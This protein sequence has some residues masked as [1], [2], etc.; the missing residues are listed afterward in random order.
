MHRLP[1]FSA[2]FAPRHLTALS[3]LVCLF[4][5]PFALRASDAQEFA[6]YLEST[7][8]YYGVF[9][10][11]NNAPLQLLGSKATLQ[12]DALRTF[13][14]GIPQRGILVSYGPY[15]FT[16]GA[17]VQ[18]G[19]YSFTLINR[20]LFDIREKL[21]Q[22]AA[23]EEG[24]K[25][26][27]QAKGLVEWNGAWVSSNALRV[28]LARENAILLPAEKRLATIPAPSRCTTCSGLGLIQQGME[29]IEGILM[30]KYTN[31]P[32]CKGTG[33]EIPMTNNTPNSA[34]NPDGSSNAPPV[35]FIGLKRPGSGSSSKGRLG[36]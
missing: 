23:A 24:F 31:C 10:Y 3:V 32:S 12:V 36:D 16:N 6:L 21:A 22:E 9:D 15:A 4:I 18:I 35:K 7:N 29:T 25:K 14:I 19:K 17:P 33:R 11:T 26:E 20:G 13:H 1:K 27:Q 2:F 8:K 5:L 28:A 34:M 30:P